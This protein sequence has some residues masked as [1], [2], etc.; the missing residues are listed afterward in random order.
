MNGSGGVMGRLSAAQNG[1]HWATLLPLFY[2]GIQALRKKHAVKTLG[3]NTLV[4]RARQKKSPQSGL[5][6]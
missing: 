6:Q 2:N 1:T 5:D 3:R 4:G